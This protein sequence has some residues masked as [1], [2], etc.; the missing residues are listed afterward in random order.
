MNQDH[1][2]ISEPV[3]PF[4]L[5]PISVIAHCSCGSP[6]RLRSE[7]FEATNWT[8][9]MR[10]MDLQYP[11]PFLVITSC[12]Q[13]RAIHKI[14]ACSSL[15]LECFGLEGALPCSRSCVRDVLSCAAASWV[16]FP[17]KQGPHP[18][19]SDSCWNHPTQ[20]DTEGAVPPL[21]P[22]RTC[23]MEEQ[24]RCCKWGGL[25]LFLCRRKEAAPKEDVVCQPTP[26]HPSQWQ[27]LA[28]GSRGEASLERLCSFPSLAV[29]PALP[30][31][32]TASLLQYS[33]GTA[34]FSLSMGSLWE[35]TVGPGRV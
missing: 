33:P 10:E 7:H 15:A 8:P 29:T 2:V 25:G 21:P 5:Q 9:R 6:C 17:K 11:H 1:E 26:W 32:S 20:E 22:G 16:L 12:S 13:A 19:A 28:R 4:V 18:A 35:A 23:S 14:R 3:S 34:H 27:P 31:H 24:S 30:C